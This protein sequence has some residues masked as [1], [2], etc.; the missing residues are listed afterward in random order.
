[1]SCLVGNPE[2]RFSR[3][4]AHI[5]TEYQDSM[6]KDKKINVKAQTYLKFFGWYGQVEEH[7]T[8]G[9]ICNA[10]SSNYKY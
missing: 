3:V 9:T 5:T 7:D 4:A 1:M 10:V 6:K 8:W 2:D